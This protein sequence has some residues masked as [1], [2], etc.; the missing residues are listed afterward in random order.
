MSSSNDYF[1]CGGCGRFVLYSNMQTHYEGDKT[2]K[3]HE[4]GIAV[5]EPPAPATVA[6]PPPP[7]MLH[8]NPIP[9]IRTEPNQP[10]RVNIK[11]MYRNYPVAF[12]WWTLI[13]LIGTALLVSTLYNLVVFH[14]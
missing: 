9:P 7:P 6:N 5:E 14:I 13:V 2:H 3:P 1:R 4:L 12:L 8:G 11:L 10:F